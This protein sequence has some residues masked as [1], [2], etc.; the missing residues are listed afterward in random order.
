MTVGTDDR[1]PGAKRRQGLLVEGNQAE[2]GM[3]SLVVFDK[4][5]FLWNT[6]AVI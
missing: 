4:E 2:H 5:T 6:Q 1:R 3:F